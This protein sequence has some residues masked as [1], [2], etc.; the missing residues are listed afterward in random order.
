MDDGDD[1]TITCSW[2]RPPPVFP[3]QNCIMSYSKHSTKKSSRPHVHSDRHS[4]ADNRSQAQA[5]Q[6]PNQTTSQGSYSNNNQNQQSA[7][8]AQGGWSSSGQYLPAVEQPTSQLSYPYQTGISQANGQSGS[9]GSVSYYDG[10]YQG[11]D[12]SGNPGQYQSYPL[13]A[14]TESESQGSY[15]SQE[16]IQQPSSS[17]QAPQR[18]T[19][20]TE[21]LAANDGAVPM[22]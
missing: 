10:A 5:T 3:D 20:G 7:D 13:Q 8:G 4:Y 17:Y 19:Q 16:Q 11:A 2:S 18:S 14:V 1:I 22:E 15:S 9:Y 21:N 6:S 12:Q